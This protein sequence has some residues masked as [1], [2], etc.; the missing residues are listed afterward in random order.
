LTRNLLKITPDQLKRLLDDLPDRDDV[1]D[2]TV[3]ADMPEAAVVA[4]H[5]GDAAAI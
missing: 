3:P 4:H 1:E 5:Y 2:G